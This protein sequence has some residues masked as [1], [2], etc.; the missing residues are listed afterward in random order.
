MEKQSS[1]IRFETFDIGVRRLYIWK[2]NGG[3]T[4]AH[5]H[6]CIELI[7]MQ[8]GEVTLTAD[9]THHLHAG[10]TVFIPSCTVHS[11]LASGECQ[12][13]VLQISL[14][15]LPECQKIL[16]DKHPGAMVLH[17]EAFD[18]LPQMF[19]I[20]RRMFKQLESF[21]GMFITEEERFQQ[22]RM[23]AELIV[24]TVLRRCRKQG[25]LQEANGTPTHM[26]SL[27]IRTVDY[28]HTHYREK[29]RLSDIAD[30][31]YCSEQ[32]LSANFRSAMHMSVPQYITSLRTT[33]VCR[34]VTEQPELSLSEIAGQTGFQSMRS[35]L[36]AFRQHY[37]CTP[38][39]MKRG[40]IP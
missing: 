20:A 15:L 32:T 5:Y 1:G 26:D 21:E 11:I 38:S 29:L 27:V 13:I 39:E 16:N 28:I 8:K 30:A 4:P 17:D 36:R 3:A 24:S 7:H 33:M 19:A 9:G 25:L 22:S 31:L 40:N 35:M 23:M 37:N 10:D 18:D 12:Y 34:L 6:E 14:A 2:Q